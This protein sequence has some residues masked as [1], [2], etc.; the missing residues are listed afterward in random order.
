M[1]DSCFQVT[2]TQQGGKEDTYTDSASSDPFAEI[3]AR[4]SQPD[5][6]RLADSCP[7][8]RL[9]SAVVRARWLRETFKQNEEPME[10]PENPEN[11][12]ISNPV[13]EDENIAERNELEDLDLIDESDTPA[14]IDIDVEEDPLSADKEPEEILP[15]DS[16]KLYLREIGRTQLLT[17]DEEIELARKIRD[18]DDMIAK[19]KMVQANLRL[20]VSIAKKYLGRGLLLP[21]LI[22]DGNLGLIHASGKFDPERG[23][24]F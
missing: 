23:Y 8:G 15:R 3:T 20:V 10:K 4:S 5:S 24:R 6:C 22:Q 17:T 9:I 7:S 16:V 19:R 14:T 18:D 2:P 11:E 1:V 12:R 21:D 13:V